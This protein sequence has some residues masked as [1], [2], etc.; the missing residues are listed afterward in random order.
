MRTFSIRT[1]AK[2]SDPEP[3][4]RN[5]APPELRLTLVDIA[6]ECGLTPNQL[7]HVLTRQLRIRKTDDQGC[8]H[9]DRQN[10]QILDGCQ[11][12]EIYDVVEAIHAELS[13]LDLQWSSASAERFELELNDYFERRGFAWVMTD[14]RVESSP[15]PAFTLAISEAREVLERCGWQTA[16]RELDEAVRD[17]SRRPTPDLT[18]A[19]QHSLAAL[20]CAARSSTGDSKATLGQIISRH[21]G[22]VLPKP[23][24][25][26]VEKLWGFASEVARHVREDTAP[27]GPETELAVH[28][29]ATVI[30]YLNRKGQIE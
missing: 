28:A 26:V 17:L 25:K 29:A 24:D 21:R 23:F 14:G 1:G 22:Q 4:I 12:S 9:V 20:E 3:V 30:T 19:L 8:Q 2:G 7:R 13:R 11:W 15:A 10:R 16:R 5:D 6:S 18:G 27:E